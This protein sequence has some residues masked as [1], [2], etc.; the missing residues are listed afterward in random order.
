M[1]ILNII[2][3]EGNN[4]TFIWK[5][6]CEDFNTLSQLIV[7]ESQEAILFRDGQALDLF[8]PGRHTLHTQNIPLLRKLINIP[9]NGESSFHCEVYF[10]NKTMPLDMKWGTRSQVVVQD[11]KFN[12]LL[13]AGANGGMG[14]QIDDSRSFLTKFVGTTQSFDKDALIDYFREMIVTHIKTYL[15]N[16]MSQVSFVTV[17]AK[18]DEMSAAMH[19]ALAEEVKKFG[20][21][22]IKFFISSIQLDK[23]DY[24]KIQI[25]LV[26]A[27]AVGI[28]ATA[29]KNRMEVL[30]YNWADQEMAEIMKSYAA[31]EGA[32][33]NIGGIVA[34]M[35]LAMAFG[36]M[37]RDNTSIGFANNG[38][39]FNSAS[40]PLGEKKYC[41]NCG[42]QLE[43]D[44]NF[45]SGCGKALTAEVMC[46]NCG[47]ILKDDENF[48]PNCGTKRM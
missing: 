5:H 2:K 24:E 42:K 4:D 48:C 35:P 31:N 18:L 38:Q 29:E 11:P 36:Q 17:N 9:T 34:Q 21:K 28:T 15:T 44:A 13:H 19:T 45:C 6:P 7:H 32:N 8:G 16:V 26:N 3:Y 46:S 10:I 40:Q 1:S 30:G 23:N 47:R 20:V 43:S 41:S 25:A 12:I 27:G 33:A 37:I 22:L 14:V 39:V